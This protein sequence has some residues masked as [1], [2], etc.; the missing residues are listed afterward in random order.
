M[1]RD[2]GLGADLGKSPISHN[3]LLVECGEI[4]FLVLARDR[5]VVGHAG[6]DVV[7]DADAQGPAAG[8]FAGHDLQQ[9]DL[10]DLA[11]LL[12]LGVAQTPSSPGASSSRS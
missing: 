5:L 6:A 7:D 2:L 11:E 10:V 8:L 4:D 3:E 9:S 12:A 1:R